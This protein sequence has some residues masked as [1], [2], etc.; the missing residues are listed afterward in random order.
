M[1]SVTGD[2]RHQ[3]TKT[4]ARVCRLGL[5]RC[6]F[7]GARVCWDLTLFSTVCVNSEL[8]KAILSGEVHTGTVTVGICAPE[9]RVHGTF[10]T[11]GRDGISP[12]G[13]DCLRKTAHRIGHLEV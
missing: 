10:L 8:G 7:A 11:G 1:V 4:E 6:T 12:R 13:L 5:V 3:V 2:M 9:H